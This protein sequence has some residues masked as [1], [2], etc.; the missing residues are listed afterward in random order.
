MELL[1]ELSS[2]MSTAVDQIFNLTFFLCSWVTDLHFGLCCFA[3]LFD[4]KHAKLTC[5]KN[6]DSKLFLSAAIIDAQIVKNCALD[7]WLKT[8]FKQ[9]GEVTK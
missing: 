4:L 6:L 7:S 8:A 2:F 5:S 1:I 3:H 9:K